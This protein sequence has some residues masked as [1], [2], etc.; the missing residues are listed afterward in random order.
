M[1]SFSHIVKAL[2]KACYNK[3]YDTIDTLVKYVDKIPLK[4]IECADIEVFKYLH[5]LE[6]IDVTENNHRLFHDVCRN[7]KRDYVKWLCSVYDRYSYVNYVNADEICRYFID[8]ESWFQHNRYS[9]V[10]DE[11]KL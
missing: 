5:N 2:P 6:K 10:D 7:N 8:G 4:L 11:K 3:D 1:T 9:Y